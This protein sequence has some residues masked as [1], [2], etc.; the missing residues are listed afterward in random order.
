MAR[1]EIFETVFQRRS[2]GAII[3]A[4]GKP[5]T[6]RDRV[7]RALSTVYAAETGATTAANPIVSGAEGQLTGW[8][9]EGSYT[10][11]P[12]G[13]PAVEFEAISGA[14][15]GVTV[16][17]EGTALT[18]RPII[19]FAGAGVSAVDDSTNGR[20]IVTI[21]GGG[22]GG[23]S[24]FIS[25]KDP[26]YNAVG[27]GT[28]NDRAAIQAAI[29]ALPAGGGIIFCPRATYG[30]DGTT[31]LTVGE[32]HVLLVGEGAGA[33]TLK[34]VGTP[35]TA[36]KLFSLTGNAGKVTLIDLTVEGPTTMGVGG[37][38]DVVE[39][40]AQV[41]HTG[42]GWLKAERCRF[43]RFTTAL[44]V[45]GAATNWLGL[46]EAQN[47]EFEGYGGTGDTKSTPVLTVGYGAGARGRLL[48]L[49]DCV[50]KNF[51][52]S[53]T[54][55]DHGVYVYPDWDVDIRGCEFVSSVGTGYCIQIYDSAGTITAANTSRHQKIVGN[56]F[57][58][59]AG[60]GVTTGR[61]SGTADPHPLIQSNTFEGTVSWIVFNRGSARIID[62]DFVG[63]GV[64]SGI[65]VNSGSPG[66]PVPMEIKQNRITG[67]VTK[68]IATG[69]GEYHITGNFFD[70]DASRHVS[71]ESN[72]V[73]SVVVATDNIHKGTV[74]GYTYALNPLDGTLELRGNRIAVTGSAFVVDA[75]ATA[76]TLKV[77]DNEF[78]QTGS[79]GVL[80]ATPA[81]YKRAR[82][83]GAAEAGATS[84]ANGGTIT[85]ALKAAPT[86]VRVTPSVAGE[87]VA[88]TAVTATN[89]TVAIQKHDG[90]AG[91]T[92]TVYWEAE[93]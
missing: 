41:G 72:G 21:T 61:A 25:I 60:R 43:Y 31:P 2:D 89:F 87:M 68:C 17:D 48:R 62:N 66:A 64:F 80:T 11:E 69:E 83:T 37:R 3:P 20:T 24:P 23:T 70:S 32:K 1:S 4:S 85:H 88:V 81:T 52:D 53:A 71:L 55:L 13:L 38:F 8:L 82:N 29:D 7:T 30:F 51:G 49:H 74:S 18:R 92:Q 65:Q 40:N 10:L 35:T 63:S 26:S 77:Y 84:V 6:V 45:T 12:E 76:S 22:G 19:N 46:I 27:D 15:A 14:T 90:T 9:E 58:P 54:S 39:A 47:C 86:Q 34:V 56:R 91:T 16:Q 75:G 44:R 50:F 28:T 67:D 79:S 57:G 36:H 93:V 5:V 59:G 78:L 33:T 42:G 73:G